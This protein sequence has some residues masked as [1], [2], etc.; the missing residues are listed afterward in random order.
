MPH[1]MTLFQPVSCLTL[2]VSLALLTACAPNYFRPTVIGQALVEQGA[3]ITLTAVIDRDKAFTQPVTVTAEGLPEGV[4]ISGAMIAP[5]AT[6]ACKR[7]SACPA[8]SW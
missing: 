1:R 5:S 4:Q 6:T 2:A 3:S 8:A 7:C